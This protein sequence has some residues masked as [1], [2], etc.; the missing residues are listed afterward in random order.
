MGQR[1]RTMPPSEALMAP[2]TDAYTRLAALYREA[3]ERDPRRFAFGYLAGDPETGAR[4]TLLWFAT[5]GEMLDFLCTNEVAL[6]Q[7]DER[8][9]ARM[10]AALRRVI[11]NTRD[12]SRLDRA[13]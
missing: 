10:T 7:F 5:P 11:G 2:S 4:A 13:I 1:N 12:V 9:V 8:D 3:T 6:L